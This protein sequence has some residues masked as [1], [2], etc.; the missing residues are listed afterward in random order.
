MVSSGEFGRRNGASRALARPVSFVAVMT[1]VAMGVALLAGGASTA[2]AGASETVHLVVHPAPSSSTGEA[3]NALRVLDPKGPFMRTL[4]SVFDD[5]ALV[6]RAAARV[7][8]GADEVEARAV[9]RPTSDV[10]DWTIS[11]SEPAA[12]RAMAAAF[13]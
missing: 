4:A 12:L 5:N 9:A 11:A 10:V 6:A 13:P 1:V 3:A 2:P 7:G 8:R